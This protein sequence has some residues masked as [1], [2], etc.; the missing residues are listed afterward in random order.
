MYLKHTFTLILVI[1]LNL[2]LVSCQD[3]ATNFSN[4]P[5][6][7]PSAGS[8]EMSFETFDSN[9]PQKDSYSG[10]DAENEEFSHFTNAVMR[11]TVLKGIVSLN[12]AIPKAL[13]AAAENTEPEFNDDG[14]WVWSYSTSAGDQQF[15]ARLVAIAQSENEIAW[16]MYVTNSQLG[17]NDRLFFEGVTANDGQTGTWSYYQLFGDEAGSPVSEVSWAIENESSKQLRLEILSDRNTHMGDFIEYEQDA[18]V[19]RVVYY[20][21]SDDETTE[22]EWNS[23]THE[24]FLIVPDY[25][26]GEKACWG[27]DLNNIT[28]S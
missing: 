13:L 7:L 11:V 12:L 10:M 24:G 14:E 6:K 4:E 27:P 25:N 17:I 3:S 23:E 26:N 9:S 18:P 15:E 20:N 1:G 21:A 5:P 22:I 2:L 19:N 8:M 28:C 16:Q